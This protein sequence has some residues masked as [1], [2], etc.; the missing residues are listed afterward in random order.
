MRFDWGRFV[1]TGGAVNFSQ[2]FGAADKIETPMFNN[3]EQADD[4]RV[5]FLPVETRPNGS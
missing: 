2:F 4:S 5:R 3:V 1:L